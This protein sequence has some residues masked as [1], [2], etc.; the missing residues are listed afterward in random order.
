MRYTAKEIVQKVKSRIYQFKTGISNLYKWF[1]VI[2]YDRNWDYYYLDKIILTKL[3]RMAEQFSKEGVH[4]DAYLQ[5]ERIL[6]THRLLSKVM[7]CYYETEYLEYY[8]QDFN[9]NDEGELKWIQPAVE[10]LGQYFDKY[11]NVYKKAV[12]SLSKREF[13]SDEDEIRVIIAVK[14]SNLNQTRARNLA[15][16]LISTYS[17]SW[18][19]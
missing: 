12:R 15:Y 6:R 4:L 19:D 9:I 17:P 13:V 7:E 2:W 3:E 10:N 1:S 16:K 11:P 18:W 14:M 8:Q 5:T